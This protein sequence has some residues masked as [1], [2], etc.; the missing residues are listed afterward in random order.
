[1]KT[2]KDFRVYGHYNDKGLFYVGA[3]S[4]K[5]RHKDSYGRGD[6]W[7]A[8]SKNGWYSLILAKGLCKEDAS[9]IESLIVSS[10]RDSLTNNREGGFYGYSFKHT[11]N[12]KNKIGKNVYDTVTGTIYP[13]IT[14]C[15]ES[16][17]MTR[18]KLKHQLRGTVI[19][20]TNIEYY[21]G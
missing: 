14:K 7:N 6:K 3:T 8:E 11:Q 16:L 21:E 12:T 19:N 18:Q 17:G 10:Y 20:K 1:M 15:A 9:D 13:S 2:S 4:K 5:Y